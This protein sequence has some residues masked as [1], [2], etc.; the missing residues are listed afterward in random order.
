MKPP[1]F[2]PQ[3]GEQQ[4][5]LVMQLLGDQLI[6]SQLFGGFKEMLERAESSYAA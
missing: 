5:S 3:D 4:S 2:N 6:M 1:A